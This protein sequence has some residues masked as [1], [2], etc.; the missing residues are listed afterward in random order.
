[1]S[2]CPHWANRSMLEMLRHHRMSEREEI[3]PLWRVLCFI[4]PNRSSHWQT[5]TGNTCH[6]PTIGMWCMLP[7]FSLN[8][9][10]LLKLITT[11]NVTNETLVSLGAQMSAATGVA[12]ICTP[13]AT[14]TVRQT[15]CQVEPS[16]L[17]SGVI[18]LSCESQ[19]DS[20]AKAMDKLLKWAMEWGHSEDL[21]QADP[22]AICFV[23]SRISNG[24]GIDIKNLSSRSVLTV[25]NMTEDHFGN[26][27]CVATNK[28]GMAN[29]SVSLIGEF[30][31]FDAESEFW[32][33]KSGMFSPLML[34]FCCKCSRCTITLNSDKPR[35]WIPRSSVF[36][37]KVPHVCVNRTKYHLDLNVKQ[38]P[39][40]R[41]QIRQ[42]ELFIVFGE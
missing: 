10:R 39:S 37:L 8:L 34:F 1:M 22:P 9:G 15:A 19:W 28:L 30:L 12:F 18:S 38:E 32:V 5:L 36:A 7:Q 4:N 27:T 40:Q 11:T 23:Y 20:G 24:Q 2:P 17:T 42:R 25:N 41:G 29:A 21:L 16:C 6:N 14:A 3:P 35:V 26:Y 13:A 31:W 33:G